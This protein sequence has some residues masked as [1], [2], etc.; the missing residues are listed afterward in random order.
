VYERSGQPDT[1]AKAEAFR[2]YADYLRRNGRYDQ[3]R[4]YLK[5][6]LRIH[7]QLGLDAYA[8]ITRRSLARIEYRLGNISDAVSKLHAV[9]ESFARR[10]GEKHQNVSQTRA[11]IAAIHLE[12]G[13][14]ADAEQIFQSVADVAEQELQSHPETISYLTKLAVSQSRRGTRQQALKTLGRARQHAHNYIQAQLPQLSPLQQVAY[15]DKDYRASLQTALSVAW[16]HQEVPEFRAASAE[17]LINGKSVTHEALARQLRTTSQP[18][19]REWIDLSEVQRRIP[20]NAVFID[21]LM[22]RS[23]GYVSGGKSSDR[24]LA[25]VYSANEEH[26]TIIDLGAAGPIDAII[27]TVRREITESALASRSIGEPKAARQCEDALAKLSEALWQKLPIGNKAKTVI[28]SPDS[29]L[30][31]VP[32]AALRGSDHP[33]IEDYDLRLVVSGRDLL[34]EPHDGPA[35]RSLI[36]ADPDFDRAQPGTARP[37]PPGS[38]RASSV[39][40]RFAEI[41]PVP[42]LQFAAAEAGGVTPSIRSL[43]RSAPQVL[44]GINA[45]EFAVKSARSP[46]ILVIATHGVFLTNARVSEESTFDLFSGSRATR[47]VSPTEPDWTTVTRENPLLRAGLLMAGFNTGNGSAGADGVLTGMEIVQMDLQG[48]ELVVLSAC[49][50]ALGEV[51]NG[52]GVAGLR[53]SFQLAG[54]GSVV[55]SLWSVD[56]RAT[57]LLMQDFFRNLSRGMSRSEALRQA[58]LSRI[59]SRQKRYGAAHPFFW[60]AFTVT[61]Q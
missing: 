35:E 14:L 47:Q 3:A 61:G 55:A 59:R 20:P 46:E 52:E 58:Q 57:A 27:R 12:Q 15:L 4:R 43:T 44:T 25:W 39:G 6:A 1:D 30:W 56:D 42:R 36:V 21:L 16:Q 13:R 31:L 24:Y 10:L 5:D 11:D 7:T 48:T 37:K 50:T 18:E 28:L 45:T 23:P 26:V 17:W 8:D 51:N 32:W 29:S 33:V 41:A 54:A 19:I 49:D 9:S 2:R 34:S 22:V 53:Q 60:A 40:S 38:S